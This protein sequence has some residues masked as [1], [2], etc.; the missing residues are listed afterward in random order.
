MLAG[1]WRQTYPTPSFSAMHVKTVDWGPSGCLRIIDQT[2]LPGEERYLDLDT[3]DAVVEAIRSLRV[4]GA[5]AIGIAAAMGLAGCLRAHVKEPRERFLDLAD[6][7][8]G[9]VAAARPTAVNL[10]WAMSRMKRLARATRGD[11]SAVLEA[12]LQEAQAIWNEDQ[13]MCRAMGENG[14]AL[15][16]RGRGGAEGTEGRRKGGEG[17]QA[18]GE[19]P[20]GAFRIL[21]HCNTGALAT[22]GI[23]TA[24][25]VVYVAAERGARVHVWVDETRPLLQGSRL[26]AWE[27]AKAGLSHAVLPDGAA[28]ALMYRGLVDLVLVGADRVA[29]NGD[30]ANKVGTYPLAI[31]AR[32]HG[33]PFYVVAPSSSFDPSCESGSEIPIEERGAEEVT[34][35]LGRQAAPQGSRAFN[36]AFDVTPAELITGWVTEKG[37][38]R[39]PFD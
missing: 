21:T 12:L 7:F 11:S 29:R 1:G 18:R 4:R 31:A 15:I 24:L 13:D 25:A 37:I 6:Q 36:P 35:P 27:L 10:G 34:H 32:H 23:G 17:E 2:L 39:P 14:Q 30:T 33:V 3:V 19:P 16:S 38:L 26:T 5:P 28:A 8:A 9:R 20:P 22:G